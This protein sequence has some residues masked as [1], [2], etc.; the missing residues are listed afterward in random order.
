MV[1]RRPQAGGTGDG[2]LR[3]RSADPGA[4]LCH[5]RKLMLGIT[6]AMVEWARAGP[7]ADVQ[8][9]AVRGC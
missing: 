2:R 5:R 4:P 6:A 9:G 8:L 3:R 1:D 7:G